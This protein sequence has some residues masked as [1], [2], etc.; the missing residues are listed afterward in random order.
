MGNAQPLGC[1]YIK[2]IRSEKLEGDRGKAITLWYVIMA[3]RGGGGQDQ[4]YLMRSYYFLNTKQ[5]VFN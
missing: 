1:Y 3:T 5:E 4:C 2:L